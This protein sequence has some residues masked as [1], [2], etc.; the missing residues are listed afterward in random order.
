MV[1]LEIRE[2]H[3]LKNLILPLFSSWDNI[4]PMPNPTSSPNGGEIEVK[5]VD[6]SNFNILQ[7]KKLK[8]FNDWSIIV[9][10]YYLGYHLL[11]E[12]LSLINEIK[13]NL[14]NFRFS[15]NKS[16]NL[17]NKDNQNINHSNGNF[18]NRLNNLFLIPS[19]YVIKNGVIFLRG[20]DSLVSENLKLICIDN[21]NNKTI[22]SSITECSK[23]LHKYRS[24]IKECLL[25]GEIYKNYKFIFNIPTVA[26]LVSWSGGEVD[27]I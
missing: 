23:A 24:K 21:F 16:I 13:N 26:P 4:S 20:T 14:N 12:G 5:G 3:Y 9:N 19:P 15:T 7:S 2:I 25:T 18:E 6:V 27:N 11:P 22:F 10:I 17:L 8:D 1:I